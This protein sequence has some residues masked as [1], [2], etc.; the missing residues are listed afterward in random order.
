MMLDIPAYVFR[1]FVLDVLLAS[2]EKNMK[3]VFGEEGGM[4]VFQM[5]T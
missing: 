4:E 5:R 3:Q 2:L 1:L